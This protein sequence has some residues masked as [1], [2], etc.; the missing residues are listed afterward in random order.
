MTGRRLATPGPQLNQRL[1][2]AHPLGALDKVLRT[3]GLGGKSR[4]FRVPDGHKA[5]Q[6]WAE[7]GLRSWALDSVF[8]A[9]AREPSMRIPQIGV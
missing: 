7:A 2:S 1:R 3:L 5:G 6:D 8:M 9:V 4:W